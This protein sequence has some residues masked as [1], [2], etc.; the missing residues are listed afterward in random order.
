MPRSLLLLISLPVNGLTLLACPMKT[1]IPPNLERAQGKQFAFRLIIVVLLKLLFYFLPLL[2]SL[3]CALHIFCIR[4]TVVSVKTLFWLY[5]K[6]VRLF[7]NLEHVLKV[8]VGRLAKL[9]EYF[10]LFIPNYFRN[11]I[12]WFRNC[13]LSSFLLAFIFFFI[14]TLFCIS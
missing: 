9:G 8:L 11:F 2:L 1:I 3:H 14:I 10:P 6:L 5:K 7:L 13:N 12:L 4:N